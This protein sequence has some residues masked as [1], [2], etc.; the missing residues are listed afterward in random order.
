MSAPKLDVSPSVKNHIETLVALAGLLERVEKTP[1]EKVG[2]D[3]YRT[4]ARQVEAALAEDM[5]DAALQAVLHAY[6]ATAEVYE[7]L[8]YAQSGLSRSGLDRS[9]GSEML[10]SQLIAKAR[11]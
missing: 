5:P 11:R 1:I 3:Q 4:L 10:A 8:H 6:P 9:V 7:N 2:A